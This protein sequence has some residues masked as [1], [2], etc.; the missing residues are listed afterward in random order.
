MRK[1]DSNELALQLKSRMDRK[2]HPVVGLLDN[3]RSLYNVGSMFRTADAAGLQRLYLTGITGTPANPRLH[4]TALGAQD[5]V[6]W[7]YEND[8]VE[9]ALRLCNQGYHLAALEL[10]DSPSEVRQ[11]PL[12]AFPLCLIVGNEV[13]GVDDRLISL[14]K[15]ALAIPLFGRKQSLNVAVAFGIAAY[16]LV[17]HYRALKKR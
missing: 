4:K 1:L 16:D 17:R 3:I 14:S 12:S 2:A 10:T 6:P 11:L 15:T 5:S 8:P 13:T 9:M 7:E